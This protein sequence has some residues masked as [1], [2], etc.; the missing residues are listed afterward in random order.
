[1]LYNVSIKR[2][3]K[4]CVIYYCL[5]VYL[6]H[7]FKINADIFSLKIILNKLYH[8]QTVFLGTKNS[9]LSSKSHWVKYLLTQ[10]E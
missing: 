7:L 3:I 1:M 5:V 6:L 2:I 8:P 10:N 9:I 4:S